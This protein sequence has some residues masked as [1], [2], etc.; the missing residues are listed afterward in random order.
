QYARDRLQESGDA[1]ATRHRDFFLSLAQEA[2][3]QL[4]GP[5]QA[6]WLERLEAEHDNLRGAL[7][8][9]A[10][11]PAS[12]EAGLRLAGSLGMF[13][14][15]HC[16]YGEGRERCRAAL[17]HAGAQSASSERVA[18]LNAAGWLANRQTDF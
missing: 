8:F 7:E 2:R 13:W 5:E 9:C 17:S 11:D 6:E 18:V 14:E 10:A 12:G 3:Q 1:V 15:T 4:L 16:H